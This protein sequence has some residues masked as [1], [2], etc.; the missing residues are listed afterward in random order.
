LT[1]DV[2]TT[3]AGLRPDWFAE[4]LGAPVIAVRIETLRFTGATTDLARVRLT[5]APEG[6]GPASVIAKITGRDEVRAG[7]DAAMG[8]FAREARFYTTFAPA[9][10]VRSPRC[11][12]AGDGR[13]TPLLLEDLGALRAGD[14]MQG[15]ALED[16]IRIID[17]IAALH[18]RFW[19]SEELDQPWLLDPADAGFADMVGQLVSSGAS[20]LRARFADRIPEATLGAV[21]EHAADWPRFVRRGV[22]GPRTLVHHDCR[23]DNIFFDGGEPVFVDW[24]V[25][26][27]ARGTQDVANLLAQSMDP[28]LLREQWENLLRRYHER[29]GVDGYPWD[30]CV[31]HYRQ[32]VLFAVG[33]GMALVGAM[34]IDD[35]R[36]LGEVVVTRALLH[37]G[38]ID[39]F[40]AMR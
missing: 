9:V 8:L 16:A 40:G 39:A 13:D 38:D 3:L 32:N 25:V 19:E 37:A 15:L 21:E 18:A 23:L 31:R 28:A 35:G 20:G 11:F 4:V 29:L 7:M 12:H 10:P 5:Y 24:Q 36:G 14:Q 2:A 30:D 26:A 33:A 34:A 17:A 22:E 27:R 6:A 1:S